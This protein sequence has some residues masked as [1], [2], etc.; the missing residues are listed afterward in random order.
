MAEPKEHDAFVRWSTAL[1]VMLLTDG[2]ID[3]IRVVQGLEAKA[4]GGPFFSG[5]SI[6]EVSDGAESKI[7]A[8]R[9]IVKNG[10]SAEVRD[11]AKAWL[12]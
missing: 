5:E 4:P 7:K 9:L 2:A 11:A 10:K 8:F 12:E 3:D 1:D 6:A